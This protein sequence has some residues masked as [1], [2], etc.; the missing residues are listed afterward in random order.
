MTDDEALRRG[1][2]S[3]LHEAWGEAHA[4]LSAADREASLARENLLQLALACLLTG[5][6]S[7]VMVELTRAYEGFLAEGNSPRAAQCAML[8]GDAVRSRTRARRCLA[9]WRLTSA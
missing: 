9:S 2:E 6:D 8:A 1:R 3:L 7:A 4:Q 5:R